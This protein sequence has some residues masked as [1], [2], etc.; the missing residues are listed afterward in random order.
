VLFHLSSERKWLSSCPDYA[1]Y[2]NDI[3]SL[4]HR[5]V[6]DTYGVLRALDGLFRF[7]VL[8]ISDPTG[9]LFICYCTHVCVAWL[10][11]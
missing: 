8:H 5:I 3:R 11:A 4:V 6:V 2:A 9:G 10:V 1:P 7:W